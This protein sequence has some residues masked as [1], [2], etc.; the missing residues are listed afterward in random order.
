MLDH[1][2]PQVEAGLPVGAACDAPVRC[3]SPPS[4]LYAY[5]PLLSIFHFGNI[6]TIQQYQYFQPRSGNI[7]TST[8]PPFPRVLA[9]HCHK[10]PDLASSIT[11]SSIMIRKRPRVLQETC[12]MCKIGTYVPIWLN[13]TSFRCVVSYALTAYT[14]THHIVYTCYHCIS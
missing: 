8:N 5:Q 11:A 4:L 1:S 12:H 2:L 3:R 10:S 9:I 14:V 6:L 7:A 13:M